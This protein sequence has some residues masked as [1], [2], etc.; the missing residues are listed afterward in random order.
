MLNFPEDM[1]IGPD[2]NLYFADTNNDR[3]RRI[4]LT[5]GV[6]DT[7][8]GTGSAATPVTADRPA[9][10]AAAAVWGS[11]RSERRSLHLG[12]VQQPH[13]QGEALIREE[14]GERDRS[15]STRPPGRA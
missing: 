11:V 13:P 14:A 15:E 2:G 6:I 7:V 9:G 1:E 8:A 4:D 3:V 5:T 10:Q 12:D